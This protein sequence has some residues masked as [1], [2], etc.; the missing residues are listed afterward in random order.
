MVRGKGEGRREGGR[1]GVLSKARKK[2][3]GRRE[4]GREKLTSAMSSQGG[5]GSGG[6]AGHIVL[7][8]YKPF[9][10]GGRESL[11][12]ILQGREE[13]RERGRKSKKRGERDMCSNFLQHA[14]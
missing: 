6:K 10:A 13:R 7:P 12:S 2:E 3:S 4:G 5:P 9:V 11:L 8:G 14:T 1:E